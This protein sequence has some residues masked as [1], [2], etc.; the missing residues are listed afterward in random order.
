MKLAVIEIGDEVCPG[1]LGEV[2]EQ[3][4]SQVNNVGSFMYEK[5]T[6]YQMP[7]KTASLLCVQGHF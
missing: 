7:H 6:P 5:S 4:D 1:H 3:Q 2:Q